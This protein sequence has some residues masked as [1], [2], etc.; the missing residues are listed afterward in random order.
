MT[1]SDMTGHLRGNDAARAAAS[2]T[3]AMNRIAEAEEIAAPVIWLL[4]PAASFVSGCR[5][6]ASGGGFIIGPG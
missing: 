6:D 2:A 3:I 5:L 1:Y 4:S